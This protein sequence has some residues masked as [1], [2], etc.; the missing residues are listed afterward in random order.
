M[1]VPSNNGICAKEPFDGA[2]NDPDGTLITETPEF[3][4]VSTGEEFNSNYVIYG[5]VGIFYL[6][7]D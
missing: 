3:I 4:A 5:L 6:S 7:V 1:F 2:I